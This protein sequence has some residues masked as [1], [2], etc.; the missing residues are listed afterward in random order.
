MMRSTVRSRVEAISFS[1]LFL[2]LFCDGERLCSYICSMC[3]YVCMGLGVENLELGHVGDA[4][5][6]F[7]S[8]G[9]L[10]N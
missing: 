9:K 6:L 7:V 5:L 8:Q 10:I 4:C 2:S 1:L 3:M